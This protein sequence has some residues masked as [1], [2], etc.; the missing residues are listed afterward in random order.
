[1]AFQR[2]Q[3]DDYAKQVLA[4]QNDRN[5]MN[6]QKVLH[7][8]LHGKSDTN[9]TNHSLLFYWYFS[10]QIPVFLA[11]LS[12]RIPPKQVAGWCVMKIQIPLVLP[13]I[14]NWHILIFNHLLLFR[15]DA[16][17]FLWN[18]HNVARGQ[19][20][21]SSSSSSTSILVVARQCLW[22]TG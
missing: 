21:R 2:H 11:I 20:R 3:N 8:Y 17:R 7:Y 22:Q 9:P 16:R 6:I 13:H 5:I 19:G 1:M 4:L 18:I 14:R 15:L 12:S 10:I